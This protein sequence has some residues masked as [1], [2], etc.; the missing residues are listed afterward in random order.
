M[1]LA[2][3]YE[4]LEVKKNS[5]A[6]IQ[7]AGTRRKVSLQLFPEVKVNDWVLVN[8]GAVVAKIEEDEARIIMQLYK[9][10]ADV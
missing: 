9:D 5:W 6:E 10:M 4:V 7:V 2:I 8:L 1:C 3:P